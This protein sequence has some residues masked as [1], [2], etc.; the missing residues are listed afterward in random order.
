MEE[1]VIIKYKSREVSWIAS[2]LN[3]AVPEALVQKAG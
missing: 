2:I 3:L 1:K